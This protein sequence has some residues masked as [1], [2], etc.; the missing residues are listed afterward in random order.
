M[1]KAKVYAKNQKGMSKAFKAS[2]PSLLKS[3]EYMGD[4][5]GRFEVKQT[6]EK[7]SEELKAYKKLYDQAVKDGKEAFGAKWKNVNSPFK[8]HKAK[9]E[10]SGEYE[11]D[12]RVDIVFRR[13]TTK[14]IDGEKTFSPLPIFDKYGK[15][16]G[17]QEIWGGS[18]LQV[19]FITN[20]YEVSSTV[21]GIQFKIVG[22]KV[23][24]HVSASGE[25]AAADGF[26]FEE[27]TRETPP[28]NYGEENTQS[29][30]VDEDDIPF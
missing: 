13:S 29:E 6:L 7:N 30:D 8:P 12:G 15:R 24:N 17:G 16:W 5:T 25:A 28:E 21:N 1:A 9:N 20:P 3:S 11:E 22:V 2:W 18:E 26:E 23:I 14:K 4:E 27:D 10:A 19:S